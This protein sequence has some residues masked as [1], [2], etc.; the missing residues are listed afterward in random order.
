M[1]KYNSKKTPVFTDSK[2]WIAVFTLIAILFV[3]V[4]A[5]ITINIINFQTDSNRI[6]AEAQ[7]E[8]DKSNLIAGEFT[9]NGL[10]L[11][12]ASN[13]WSNADAPDT[14]TI[15]ASLDSKF[16]GYDERLVWTLAYKNPNCGWADY[17][18][19]DELIE[20]TVSEDTHT[21][22]VSAKRDLC[23]PIILTAT[24][25]DNPNCSASC[26]IDYVARIYGGYNFDLNSDYDEYGDYSNYLRFDKTNIMDLTI[27]LSEGTIS[28]VAAIE[29][30]ELTI[31]EEMQDLINSNITGATAK[32]KIIMKVD[33]TVCPPLQSA[34]EAT[35]NGSINFVITDLIEGDCDT[36]QLRNALYKNAHFVPGTEG[37][38]F[39]NT[40]V[41]INVSVSH[42]GTVYQNYSYTVPYAIMF[43]RGNLELIPAV[44]DVI[45]DKENIIF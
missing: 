25:V 3:G 32:E 6:T 36:R 13:S 20:L 5:S 4:I 37:A 35:L 40:T 19:V 42:N 38:E 7:P 8:G 12:L 1:K 28:P 10:T 15:T 33:A 9:G 14:V 30:I 39:M 24:S 43:E 26:Q 27:G 16:G 21:V 11:S 2:K 41:T 22:T 31:P 29:S 18:E 34:N 23:E 45:L 44:T 17:I